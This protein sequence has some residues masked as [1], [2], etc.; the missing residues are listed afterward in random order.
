M[1]EKVGLRLSRRPRSPGSFGDPDLPY[2][3]E[4]ASSINN[5]WLGMVENVGGSEGWSGGMK[6]LRMGRRPPRRKR[7][8]YRQQGFTARPRASLFHGAKQLPG[9]FD[10]HT[11]VTERARSERGRQPAGGGGWD[12][13]GR[14][15]N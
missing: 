8:T 7:F 10:A 12:A 4:E 3:E 11:G 2:E 13:A 1:A 15:A 5:E 6:Y 14:L 9:I